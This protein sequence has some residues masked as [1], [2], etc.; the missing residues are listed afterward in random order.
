MATDINEE[1]SNIYKQARMAVDDDLKQQFYNAAQTRNQAFRQLNNNANARHSLFSGMPAATQMQYDRNTYLPGIATATTQ[2]IAR[3]QSNQEQWDQ[4]MA[5]VK[6][7]NEQADYY[8]NLANEAA[9]NTAKINEAL[10]NAGTTQAA[11]G[12][13]EKP[14]TANQGGYTNF[15]GEQPEQKGTGG[16]W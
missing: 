5:Y 16:G 4:Y 11:G 10:N 12:M 7:L 14:A 8:N 15:S 13:K 6:E 9:G 3:Q 2:A 1:L